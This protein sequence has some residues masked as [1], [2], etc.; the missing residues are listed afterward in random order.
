M[1]CRAR[2]VRLICLSAITAAILMVSFTGRWTFK[3]NLVTT[4]IQTRPKIILLWG[5]EFLR[6]RWQKHG[7]CMSDNCEKFNVTCA[8]GNQ[9]IITKDQRDYAKSTGIVFD[10][11]HF[12]W[13]IYTFPTARA[14]W[15][16]WIMASEESQIRSMNGEKFVKADLDFTFNMTLTFHRNSD[17]HLSYQTFMKLKK[18][19]KKMA[20]HALGRT[21]STLWVV[22]NC[23]TPSKRI[24][25][26]RQLQ[27]SGLKVDIRGRCAK[28]PVC[29]SKK[30]DCLN[31]LKRKYKFY[32]AFEN[33]NCKDY[34]TEKLWD[35][36]RDGLLPVCLGARMSDYTRI[37]PPNSFLHVENFTSPRELANHLNYLDKNDDAYNRYFEWK[38]QLTPA[39]N[40]SGMCDLCD[41]LHRNE[42]RTIKMSTFWTEKDCFKQ[43]YGFRNDSKF[44]R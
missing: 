16:S 8:S 13:G 33:S 32:L 1:L 28:R 19:K 3:T 27:K 43:D 5:K 26:V 2:A 38:K 36:L 42:T 24:L 34:I 37:A 20:N 10:V 23:K 30:I 41:I 18:P 21:R 35:A 7:V 15:Q 22:S 17:V 44:N 39:P 14:P 12:D 25:Y 9:C 6:S 4:K 29:K 40:L 31:N 11:H